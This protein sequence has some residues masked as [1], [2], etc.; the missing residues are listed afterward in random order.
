[1]QTLSLY[2]HIYSHTDTETAT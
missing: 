1:M 2:G